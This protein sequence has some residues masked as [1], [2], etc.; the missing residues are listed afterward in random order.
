MRRRL[1]LICV[2][3]LSILMLS[4]CKKETTQS[5]SHTD[6]AMGT[7]T[8]ISLYGTATEDKLKEKEENLIKVVKEIEDKQISWRVKDS[9]IS[10]L[11][12]LKNKNKVT[13]KEPLL[14]W[15]KTSMEISREA[16]G[17]VDGSIGL[18]TQT[19]DFESAH[20]VA[21]SAETIK[22]VLKE[23]NISGCYKNVKF[24]KNGTITTGKNVKFDLGAFGKGIGI[25]KVYEMMK[26]DKT[27]SGGIV[28]LGGSVAVY[29]KKEDGQSWNVGVQNPSG[30]QG[31]VLGSLK[32]EGGKFISTS[33]DYEKYFIDKK[34]GKRYFHILDENTGY[35]VD[36]DVKSCTIVCDSGIISDG[37]STACFALG[38][39]KSQQ[40]LKKY[41]AKAIFVDKNHKV[42]VSKG[43]EFTLQDN[44]YKVIN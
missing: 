33:G 30:E 35:S 28:A 18:L 2:T 10:K 5:Y 20:P 32:L 40:L 7:V 1:G 31:E 23:G 13:V 25:D 36:T 3:M 4:G 44:R 37:L 29:G 15:L 38:P 11:N 16:S 26:K 8:N 22:K 42:T 17:K 39:K 27:I 34:T 6:F 9:A 24:E 41:N 43:L 12:G 21:P 19:W 14:S